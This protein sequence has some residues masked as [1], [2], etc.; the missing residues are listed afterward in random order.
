MSKVFGITGWKNSGK[1][2][3]VA[4]L[5]TEFTSRG[6]RVSTIKHASKHFEIDKPG[7]DS[8]AHRSAG[9]MEVAIISDTKWAIIHET[10]LPSQ[11]ISLNAMLAKLAPCDLVIVEGFKSSDVPKIECQ[12]GKESNEK[13]IWQSNRSIVALACE[14]NDSDCQLPQFSLDDIPGIADYIAQTSG[15]GLMS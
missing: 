5:V 1:T 8:H 14:Y 7:T 13:A 9:A 11:T 6:F 15:L 12:R 4:K 2:T 3:L 10:P